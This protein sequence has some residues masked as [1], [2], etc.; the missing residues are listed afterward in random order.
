MTCARKPATLV[1][2]EVKR[3]FRILFY[4]NRLANFS[5]SIYLAFVSMKQLQAQAMNA[6]AALCFSFVIGCTMNDPLTEYQEFVK[7]VQDSTRLQYAR[8][9]FVDDYTLERT[10]NRPGVSGKWQFL[11]KCSVS[12]SKALRFR[13][14][15]ISIKFDLMAR[16]ETAGN[17]KTSELIPDIHLTNER[18]SALARDQGNGALQL[19]RIMP[20]DI[21]TQ[22]I[23]LGL[24]HFDFLPPVLRWIKENNAKLRVFRKLPSTNGLSIVEVELKAFTPDQRPIDIVYQLDF[25]YGLCRRAE[26]RFYDQTGALSATHVHR[27]EYVIANEPGAVPIPESRILTISADG[28][29][30]VERHRY[31]DF[32]LNT[33]IGDGEFY[34]SHYGL[35]EPAIEQEGSSIVLSIGA[36][37]VV[38][39]FAILVWR[40]FYLKGS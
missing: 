5:A 21:A 10:S 34:L 31:V 1:L 37:L 7:A 23:A 27:I 17:L 22:R 32:A 40:V 33:R 12:G 19:L 35:P 25:Q 18:Y 24:D 36:G 20:N 38:I 26:F 30:S 2:M 16:D 13:Y 6:I 8:F 11:Q 3:V 39:G 14:D 15:D 4:S 29:E 28:L 9:A